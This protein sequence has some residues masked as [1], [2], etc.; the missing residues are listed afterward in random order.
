MRRTFQQVQVYGIQDRR[1]TG[2]PKPWVV[3]W[4]VDGS[5]RS[6]AFRTKAEAERFRSLLLQAVHDGD[7][8]DTATGEPGSWQVPLSDMT[9]YAWGRRWLSEQWVEWQPRTRKSAIESLAKLVMLAVNAPVGK[10]DA[11]LRRYLYDAF[12]PDST[13]RDS[14]WEKWLGDHSVLLSALDREIIGSLAG[15]TFPEFHMA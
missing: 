15:H 11:E 14:R 2:K 10:R 3:R 5:Q 9:L 4:S 8:F 6:R 12:P 7:K 13:T 1:S